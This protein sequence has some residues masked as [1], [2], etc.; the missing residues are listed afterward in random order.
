MSAE[1]TAENDAHDCRDGCGGTPDHWNETTGHWYCAYGN[2]ACVIPPAV[3][4]PGDD[5]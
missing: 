2:D 5:Q 3:T 1:H 4:K